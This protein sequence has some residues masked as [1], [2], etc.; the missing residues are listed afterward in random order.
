MSDGSDFVEMMDR[1]IVPD[2][3]VISVRLNRAELRALTNA[4]RFHN[5]KLSTWMKQQCMTAAALPQVAFAV[6]KGYGTP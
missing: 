6:T 5:Q 2:S 1:V 3:I 4:A